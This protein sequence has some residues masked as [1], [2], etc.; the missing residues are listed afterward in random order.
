MPSFTAIGKDK[1]N[2]NEDLD[3]IFLLAS[4]DYELR[5][6]Y[7][8]RLNKISPGKD[9]PNGII[10]P[11]A[12]TAILELYK[13]SSYKRYLKKRSIKAFNFSKRKLPQLSK[14]TRSNP[15]MVESAH[16]KA[17]LRNK[18][19]GFE[20]KGKL[21]STIIEKMIS[22]CVNERL[23][24]LKIISFFR[25]I[26]TRRKWSLQVVRSKAVQKI[27]S[28]AR[29]VLHKRSIQEHILQKNARVVLLQS[30]VRMR[31]KRKVFLVNKKLKLSIII[32]IQNRARV[33]QAR[34]ILKRLKLSRTYVKIQCAYRSYK[35]RAL[36]ANLKRIHRAIVIQKYMRRY[37]AMKAY[38]TLESRLV[39][40]ALKVQR[41]F[42]LI[43]S[44]HRVKDLASKRKL[45]QLQTRIYFLN[46]EISRQTYELKALK[47]KRK[48]II[49]RDKN[50]SVVIYSSIISKI[51][52]KEK[53]FTSSKQSLLTMTFKDIQNLNVTTIQ[54]K[55]RIL[56]VCLTKLKLYAIFGIGLIWKKK[57]EHELQLEKE[58]Q[59]I[60]FHIQELQFIKNSIEKV[61]EK[62]T[63]LLS[64]Q[65]ISNDIKTT[66]YHVKRKV[67][68]PKVKFPISKGNTEIQSSHGKEL[69]NLIED[70]RQLISFQELECWSN[71]MSNIIYNVLDTF[72]A[73]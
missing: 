33:W 66:L 9:L 68:F 16:L 49:N 51:K 22:R 64:Q 34:R 36:C 67:N 58:E 53:L 54:E 71:E 8:K 4:F 13:S 61:V 72:P 46:Q 55:I 63:S 21:R 37:L 70:V 35:A 59:N 41:L 47:F 10:L 5:I 7:K 57:E 15:Y 3:R 48:S 6:A 23:A 14:S 38:V 60:K 56:R 19:G 39:A 30:L 1:E 24:A 69:D 2:R 65:K 40:S 27:Q 32:V 31:I 42:R 50:N 20:E 12:S 45:K 28:L 25:S 26:V 73:E 11:S 62:L 18:F 44:R 17:A 43:S 52:D 29:T